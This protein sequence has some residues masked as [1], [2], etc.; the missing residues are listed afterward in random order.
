MELDPRRLLIF[1]RVAREG[2]ITGAARAL[3]WT[4]PAVSQHLAH[5]ERD[6]GTRLLLRGPGGVR[7]T[8]AGST[9]LARADAVAGELHAAREEL[10]SLTTLGTGRV[11]LRAF[12]SA[13]A[14]LVSDAVAA[15][16]ERH[17]AVEVALVAAEPPEATAAVRAGDADLAVVFGYDGPPPALGQLR[18][19]ELDREPVHLVVHPEHPSAGARRG[20]LA[21]LA[22]ERW[23]AGCVRCREHLVDCC[24]AAGFAPLITHETDD[25][26]VVQNLVARGLGVTALPASALTAYRHPGV[27]LV[28]A[29]ALGSRHVGL[30]HRPGAETVPATAALIRELG[31]VSRRTPRS[32]GAVAP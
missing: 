5:L 26:V 18:W 32:R 3:G 10:A 24:T 15:L 27:V 11:R 28:D 22:D 29:P 2:S 12:P 1:R 21:R 19:H 23:I 16:G 8:Q 31:R 14:T 7:L 20:D 25:Y 30:V 9:L 13:A 17:P 6:A 4:Q